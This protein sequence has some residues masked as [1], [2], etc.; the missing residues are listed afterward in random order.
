MRSPAGH[1]PEPCAPRYRDRQY[2]SGSRTSGKTRRQGRG[3]HQVLGGDGSAH[4]P[5]V[6]H[7][8]AATAGFPRG[9]EP[10]GLNILQERLAAAMSC[11]SRQECCSHSQSTN[12]ANIVEVKVPDIGNFKDVDVIEVLVKP[13]DAI[14]KEQGL[15]TLETDKATMDV[16]APEAGTVKEMKVK[17]GDKV[18]EGSLILTLELAGAAPD[19]AGQDQSQPKEPKPA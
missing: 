5:A 11:E 8:A 2:R 19:T 16:P 1:A 10:L 3:T 12:M 18:S 7:R 14:E 13:G 15:I 17:Q 4:R 9:R 6:L